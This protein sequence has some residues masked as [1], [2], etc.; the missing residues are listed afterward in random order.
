[1]P[2][3]AVELIRPMRGGAQSHLMRAADGHY[4]V[5]KFVNNPQHRR[6]L[7]N[8]WLGAR[9]ARGLGLPVPESAIIEVP[10]LLVDGS[11][12]LVMRMAG[13]LAPCA[14]GLQFGSRL[15]TGDPHAPIYDYLPEPGLDLVANLGDF[16][17][18]LL[19]DKWTCN[20]DG[21]QV[22][23]CRPVRHQP[24]RDF[25]VD[26]GFCFNAGDWDFPDSPLRG[27]YNRN[28]VYAGVTGWASFEPWLGRLEAFA[29]EA[30]FAAGEEVPPD[31][32]GDWNEMEQLLQR[33]V[34]RRSRVRELVLAVKASPRAPFAN[35]VE[36]AGATHAG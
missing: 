20:C 16:A 17:G 5:V 22:V 8:E 31:W 6:V 25:M 7:A 18:M 29:P 33:L 9:L 27:V 12:G 4:Y 1:M 13:R 15:P 34:R 30:I 26:Q 35:W 10:P 32:Y 36:Q 28:V 14:T 21:R 3:Q 2:V 24:L 11:P 23:F 19:F